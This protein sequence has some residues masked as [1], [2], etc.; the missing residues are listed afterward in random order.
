MATLQLPYKLFA[1]YFILNFLLF[2][3]T[4]LFSLFPIKKDL[5]V[6]K[7]ETSNIAIKPEGIKHA[8]N[9]LVVVVIDSLRSD[10]IIDS[11][12]TY[13]TYTQHLLEHNEA[14]AYHSIAHPPT[15]TLPRIKA[16]M[17]G[18][19]PGFMDVILN[20][21]AQASKEDN[22]I[23]QFHKAGKKIIFYGDNTWINLFPDYFHRQDG[24]VSFFVTD[25]TEVDVNVS[26]HLEWELQQKDWDVMVLHYLGLDHIGHMAKPSSPLVKPKLQEM[27]SVI[28]LIHGKL[29]EQHEQYPSIMVVCGDHGMSDQGSHG[30]SSYKEVSSAMVWLYSAANKIKDIKSL[31]VPPFS[32]VD[33]IDMTATLAA[34]LGVEIPANN[35]G[36]ILPDVLLPFSPL[37]DIADSMYSNANQILSVFKIYQPKWENDNGVLQYNSVV[38]SH[39]SWRNASA[40]YTADWY[41][42]GAMI[43]RFYREA[44]KTMSSKMLSKMV[45]HDINGMVFSIINLCLLL[46]ILITVI[47]QSKTYHNTI[48]FAVTHTSCLCLLC[49]GFVSL[50]LHV[51]VC[52]GQHHNSVL[53]SNSVVVVF[54]SSTFYVLLFLAGCIT[55]V[56]LATITKKI[57]FQNFI[58]VFLVL[59]T[60]LHSVSLMSSSFI[61]EEHQTWYFLTSSL[62]AITCWCLVSRLL[63][64]WRPRE[65]SPNTSVPSHISYQHLPQR[66]LNSFHRIKVHLKSCAAA[67]LLLV[68]CRTQRLWN[69]TGD[70][71]RDLPDLGDWFMEPENKTVLSGVCVL[72]LLFII[73]VRS[74]RMNSRGHMLLL[75]VA[76]SSTYLVHA[77]N[78]HIYLPSTLL[79]QC[80]DKGKT[81]AYLIKLCLLLMFVEAFINSKWHYLSHHHH[82][83]ST[84]TNNS[85]NNNNHHGIVAQYPLLESLVICLQSFSIILSSCLTSYPHNMAIVA[86]IV[87]QEA[88]LS[89]YI[90]PAVHLSCWSMSLIYAWMASSTYFSQGHSNSLSSI[91]VAAGYVSID[92]YQPFEVGIQLS[93]ATYSGMLFWYSSLVS[94]VI[95]TSQQQHQQLSNRLFV[96]SLTLLLFVTVSVPTYTILVFFQR[97]HLFIWTVF[98]P[99]LLFIGMLFVVTSLFV[100]VILLFLT[101]TSS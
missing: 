3:S 9:R 56:F 76:L 4:F 48:E 22:L 20:F 66:I 68:M 30:G 23:F 6:S 86:I 91:D 21:G 63:P 5:H 78:N 15:V 62:F 82:Y 11:N 59:G 92:H 79:Y 98:S 17:T 34:A 43:I 37:E 40:K 50:F 53:C 24:T 89:R 18:T 12:N 73:T 51:I 72:S 10:F 84:T 49:V 45:E 52:S 8:F 27:D 77:C 70:K 35:I 46:Y 58:S 38:S 93:L 83:S 67:F 97:S 16:M 41:K 61:E 39:Q 44:I 29:Q 25:Y 1:L 7:D 71:W 64:E 28:K 95:R 90:L 60:I 88:I 85:N 55:P 13:M 101:A 99:K 87:V 57:S 75:F 42:E 81:E 36:A 31:I 32:N 69:N 2:Y 94:H 33:Q 65:S 74:Y 14:I 96:S 26:R 19:I 80:S 47:L 54:L 100:A